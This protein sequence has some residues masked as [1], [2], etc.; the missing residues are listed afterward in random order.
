MKGQGGAT[1][2][3]PSGAGFLRQAKGRAPG[4][5]L[6]V[7]VTAHAEPGKAPPVTDR[8]LFKS[9][10]AIVT[11]DAPGLNISRAIRDDAERDRL[12]EIAHEA[13]AGSPFG[14]ILRS[15]AEGA[16]ADEIAED[17][18]TMLDLAAKVTADE[19][20]EPELLVE[21]DGPHAAAW[22]EWTAPAEID[23]RPGAFE[24]HG[25]LDAV[26]ALLDPRVAL[27]PASMFV[28][29]TRALV[30]VDVNTGGDAS[31]AAGLKANLACARELPR[32][33]RL[34]GPRRA[35]DARPRTPHQALPPRLRGR[36]AR[37][38]PRRSGRDD[39]GRLDPL[40]PL[41]APPPAR[42]RAAGRDPRRARQGGRLMSC[43]D[44]R[45]RDRPALPPLL[46]APAAP[47]WISAAG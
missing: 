47:T 17:I 11:P 12:L 33:L 20:R 2:R 40:G 30:A 14:L 46:L 15:A 43:P 23:G 39:A 34:R 25:V 3:L 41:R 29:P 44:L 28:E 42:A 6:V 1:V 21:A 9:R 37:R 18:R 27:G 4:E 36:A 10:H 38:L 24:R 13:M 5:S 32:Q 45:A 22:R 19:G 31:P 16:E 8:P 7:Q 26:D 35:G